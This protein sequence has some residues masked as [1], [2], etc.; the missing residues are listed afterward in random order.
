MLTITE[1]CIQCGSCAP[2]C[3]NEAIDWLDQHFVIDVDKC[4]QC[5]T[6]RE[7]CPID[8][9]IVDVAPPTGITR[10]PLLC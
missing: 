7:Y 6:C 9:A 2:F 8:G 5:G 4:D 3:E 1:E 10:T